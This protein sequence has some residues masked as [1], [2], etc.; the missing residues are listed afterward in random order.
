M[1]KI[2]G[3]GRNVYVLRNLSTSF[4]S[5]QSHNQSLAR[6]TLT[7]DITPLNNLDMLTFEFLLTSDVVSTKAQPH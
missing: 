3:S 4:N 6:L 1:W 7:F 5:N 2:F